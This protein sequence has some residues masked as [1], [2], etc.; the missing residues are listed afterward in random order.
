MAQQQPTP[1][2][3]QALMQ[4]NQFG[5]TGDPAMQQQPNAQQ[6]PAPAPPGPQDAAAGII[7]LMVTILG[8][9]QD[10]TRELD[11]NVLATGINTLASA[12]KALTEQQQQVD[13]HI[14]ME[15][16][17]HEMEL[18][19]QQFEMQQAI[20][21]HDMQLKQAKFDADEDRAKED[22]LLKQEIAIRKEQRETES[23]S[24]KD[25][26]AMMKAQRE[27]KAGTSDS[28]GK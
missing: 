1:E 27:A 13:P 26:I 14:E 22:H 12:Y 16:A 6:A 24:T 17:A 23:M 18:K 28:S 20:A 25:D 2:M 5:G 21:Q 7:Q 11:L 8:Q 10:K 9:Q 15:K 19:Q 4:T 3:I